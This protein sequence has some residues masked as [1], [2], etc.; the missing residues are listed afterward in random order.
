MT[1]T[2]KNENA[3]DRFVRKTRELFGREADPEQR[4]S[5]LGPILAELLADKK[6]IDASRKWPDCVVVDKRAENLL[7][8]EDPDYK[9]VVNGLVVN[10]AGYQNIPRVH[11]HDRIY[12]LYGLIDGRQQIQRYERLDDKSKPN[13]AEIRKTVD[14]TCGPGEIDLVRPYE[15]HSEDTVGDRAVAVIVRSEIS[16]NIPSARY[17][18]EENYYWMVDGP[19]QT[20]IPFF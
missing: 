3:F 5:S 15:I 4:W 16:E 10:E 7:F 17:V 13:H 11:D 12:T 2:D 8:Y 18:P 20:R 9:F 14:V 6:A 1:P 19:R